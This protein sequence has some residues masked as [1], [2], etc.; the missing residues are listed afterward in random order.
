MAAVHTPYSVIFPAMLVYLQTAVRNFKGFRTS[1]TITIRNN[2]QEI[3]L[4]DPEN[5]FD[6][7]IENPL[8]PVINP[9]RTPESS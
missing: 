3:R 6:G 9:G 7:D 4:T 5:F 1:A 8:G 2:H